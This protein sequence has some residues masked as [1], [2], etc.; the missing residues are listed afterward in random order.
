MYK[1][2]RINTFFKL[3]KIASDSLESKFVAFMLRNSFTDFEAEYEDEDSLEDSFLRIIEEIEVSDLNHTGAIIFWILNENLPEQKRIGFAEDFFHKLINNYYGLSKFSIALRQLVSGRYGGNSQSVFNAIV[4]SGKFKDEL[5]NKTIDEPNFNNYALF[6]SVEL[7]QYF[8]NKYTSSANVVFDT[9][10]S[11]DDIGWEEP[12]ELIKVLDNLNRMGDDAKRAVFNVIKDKLS[13][14]IGKF[15]EVNYIYNK[16][17]MVEGLLHTFDGLLDQAILERL[18]KLFVKSDRIIPTGEKRTEIYIKEIKAAVARSDLRRMYELDIDRYLP[19]YERSMVNHV[20]E[21][22]LSGTLDFVDADYLEKRILKTFFRKELNIKFPEIFDKVIR[23]VI[24]RMPNKFLGTSSW[25]SAPDGVRL[26]DLDKSQEEKDVFLK[27]AL[28]SLLVVNTDN[29]ANL[30]V[31]AKEEGTAEVDEGVIVSFDTFNGILNEAVANTELLNNISPTNMETLFRNL[32][33]SDD[34]DMATVISV[35]ENLILRMDKDACE[36]IIGSLYHIEPDQQKEVFAKKIAKAI[37]ENMDK[38]YKCYIENSYKINRHLDDGVSS[39]MQRRALE[40]VI[41]AKDSV[42]YFDHFYDNYNRGYTYALIPEPFRNSIK[43]LEKIRNIDD[44]K[45][46][47]NNSHNDV[48]VEIASGSRIK[49]SGYQEQQRPSALG[50]NNIPRYELTQDNI[51]PN[52]IMY[53]INKNHVSA[54]DFVMHVNLGSSGFTTAWALISFPEDKL[55]IEQIQS[56]YPVVL[57]RVFNRM[58]PSKKT[59]RT[60]SYKDKDTGAKFELNYDEEGAG[61]FL[62]LKGSVEPSDREEAKEP[63]VSPKIRESMNGSILDIMSDQEFDSYKDRA[64]EFEEIIGNWNS[65]EDEKVKAQ[66]DAGAIYRERAKKIRAM[67]DDLGLIPSGLY[68]LSSKYSEEDLKDAKKHVD[69]I[70]QNYPYLIIINAIKTAQRM[71][72]ESVYLLKDGGGSIQNRHKRRKIYVDIPNALG[73]ASDKVLD[74]NVFKISAT[75]ESISKLKEMLPIRKAHGYDYSLLPS[76]NRVIIQQR[77]DEDRAARRLEQDKQDIQLSRDQIM[78]VLKLFDEYGIEVSSE[79]IDRVD[80]AGDL[81]RLIGK[82][83][84]ALKDAGVSKRRLNKVQSEVARLRLAEIIEE[85]GLKKIGMDKAIP[86]YSMLINYEL[87]KE[88]EELYNMFEK[89]IDNKI[90]Y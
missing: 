57:D 50:E 77:H 29:F 66:Q 2:S 88:A 10:I 73:A 37:D 81:L 39:R 11:S 49:Y 86:L 56:D 3:L 68:D 26:H 14:L 62:D 64:K 19:R 61:V 46:I 41:E 8:I 17:A 53:D 58:P 9:F 71:N 48:E 69:I 38:H 65:T 54:A 5:D 63:P 82:Y 89:V 70:S 28:R 83:R 42:T 74:L 24:D 40:A 52:P 79:E 34:P 85:F 16:E 12:Q 31:R 6:N 27:E 18:N 80:T 84:G 22:A 25:Y 90:Y 51:D 33:R 1:G 76:Q 47:Y 67:L 21:G 36:N 44:A 20:I 45:E 43:R 4:T 59:Y 23:L 75:D 55:L 78:P 72:K 35:F 60:I 30:F 13:S 7:K 15:E 87:N 32:I